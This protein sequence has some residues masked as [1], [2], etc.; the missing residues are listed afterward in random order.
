MRIILAMIIS[1]FFFACTKKEEK[2]ETAQMP[3]K[4]LEMNEPIEK[5]G[6]QLYFDKRFSMDNSISCNTCHDITHQKPGTDGLA[7]SK[8]INSQFGGRNAP[9]V[10]NAKFLS[11]QFWDGR[12]KDLADQAKGPIINPIEMGMTDHDMAIS[13]IKDNEAYKELFKEAFPDDK[14][15][16]NIENAAKAIAAFESLLTT[17]DSPFDKYKAGDKSALSAEAQKGYELFQSVGCISCHSGDHFSGPSMPTGTGFFMKFPTFEDN[18]YV[19][20]YGF[21]QD[22]GRHQV[23]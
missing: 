2:K 5:L 21:K 13:R 14:N 3:T 6:Y 12:A 22:T 1:S 23:T 4:K 20:K 7:T 18:E 8:G 15:P 16:V 19:K 10:W 17:T 11:V 9:T